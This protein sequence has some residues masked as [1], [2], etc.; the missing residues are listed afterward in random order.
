MATNTLRARFMHL[1]SSQQIKQRVV[2]LL[3]Q[4]GGSMKDIRAIM[5][6]KG[7]KVW[8]FEG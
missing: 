2:T 1:F 5:R 8:N 4:H 6:G 7:K 3:N